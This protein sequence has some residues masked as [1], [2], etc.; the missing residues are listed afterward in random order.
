MFKGASQWWMRPRADGEIMGSDESCQ[1]EGRD[2]P[3]L[4]AAVARHLHQCSPT[5]LKTQTKRRGR[6]GSRP[7][8]D[9]RV[10]SV[11]CTSAGSLHPRAALHS[12]HYTSN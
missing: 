6:D 12:A 4:V 11:T 2:G 10:A 5:P 3:H 7:E 1:A 9:E 8:F